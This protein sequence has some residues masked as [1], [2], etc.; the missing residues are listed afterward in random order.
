[1]GK[2]LSDHA[3]SEHFS[4]N[5]N[6][7]EIEKMLYRAEKEMNHHYGNYIVVKDKK[8]RIYHARNYKALQGV[9]KTLRWVLGDK[10]IMHPL[11]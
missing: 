5:R 9:V 6:W 8:Q 7:D 2:E 10:N 11:D 3:D 1:M 4:Y